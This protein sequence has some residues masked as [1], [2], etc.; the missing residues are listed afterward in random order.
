MINLAR[1]K[2]QINQSKIR[3]K[4]SVM[5]KKPGDNLAWICNVSWVANNAHM[6]EKEAEDVLRKNYNADIRAG[7]VLVFFDTEKDAE[8][9]IEW[10]RTFDLIDKLRGKEDDK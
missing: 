10:F 8:K 1:R 2:F 3:G 5:C 4:Y 7:G 9:I 6:S